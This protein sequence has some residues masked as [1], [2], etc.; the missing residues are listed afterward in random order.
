MPGIDIRRLVPE[1]AAL[2]REIRLEALSGDPESFSSSFAA[3]AA[4]PLA[5]FA[6]R[7]A[8]SETF[9]AFREGALVGMAGYFVHPEAKRA[10]KATLVGMYVQPSARK[11]GIARRLVRTVIEAARTRVEFI[12]LNVVS[13]NEAARKLY[14]EFGFTEY[15]REPKALKVEGR[16]LDELLLVLPLA[17]RGQPAA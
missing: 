14:A 6:D 1:D 2:Y 15:G 11:R 5:W 13:N 12:Q 10:H 17:A 16:Y 4:H 3:E 9:G 7:L 8:R